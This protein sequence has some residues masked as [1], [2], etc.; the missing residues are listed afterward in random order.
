MKSLQGHW[1]EEHIFEL[2]HA[3]ELYR[4]YQGKIAECDGEIEAQLERFEDRSDGGSPGDN[5]R[6]QRQGNAPRCDVQT[7][8]YRMT[9]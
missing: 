4:F 1:Q 2:T 3:L 8:L 7:H 5:G 9:G 6:R